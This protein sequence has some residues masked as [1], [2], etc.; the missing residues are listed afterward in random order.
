MAYETLLYETIAGRDGP[1]GDYSMAPA[2]EKPD[3]T[4]VIAPG[5]A[6]GRS[7]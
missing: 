5:K 7:R 4:H 3:P 2:S 6:G 1:F